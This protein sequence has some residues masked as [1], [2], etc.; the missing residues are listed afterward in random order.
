[1]VLHSNARTTPTCSATKALD[2]RDA[3]HKLRL[4]GQHQRLSLELLCCISTALIH[5]IPSRLLCQELTHAPSPLPELRP[6]P[7]VD[8]VLLHNPPVPAN[9]A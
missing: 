5:N 9:H 2:A 6:C 3:T 4:F 7:G 1:M 8:P